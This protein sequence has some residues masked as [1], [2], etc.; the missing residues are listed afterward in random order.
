MNKKGFTLVE[1]VTTFALASAI[2]VLLINIVVLI[3]NIYTKDDVKTKLYIEQGNLSNEINKTLRSG[4]ILSYSECSD[5]SFCYEFN[6]I[7]GT[8]AKLIVNNDTIK[9][10]NVVYKLPKNTTIGTPTFEKYNINVSNTDINDSIIQIKI[11]VT[12]KLYSN[13]DFGINFI[14]QYNSSI[15]NL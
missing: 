6:L 13:T 5:S 1:L 9:F 7:D 10:K 4:S 8:S 11:P 15:T 2:I 3:K 12:S 14:Y